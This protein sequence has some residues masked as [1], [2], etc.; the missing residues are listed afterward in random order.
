MRNSIGRIL[1]PDIPLKQRLFQLLSA[2]ALAE[3]IIVTIYTVLSGG[4][5]EHI[6]IMLSG[7]AMFT[8]TVA[9]TSRSEKKRFG[10]TVSGLCTFHFTPSPILPPVGC[11]AVLL[12]CLP[13]PW[14]TYFL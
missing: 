14:Y 1:S 12:R 4:N 13:L 5:R 2:I 8:A 10:A 11:M 6:V 3:F 9:F 7:T